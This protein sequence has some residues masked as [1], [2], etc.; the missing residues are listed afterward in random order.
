MPDTT[1]LLNGF[2][3]LDRFAVNTRSNG[4][5]LDKGVMEVSNGRLAFGED[6][7]VTI[8]VQN[9]DANLEVSGSS[10]ITGIKVY[11]S[12]EDYR[13]G[14]VQYSYGPMNPGQSANVQSDVSGLGDTYMRFNANVLVSS[15]AGAPRLDQLLVSSTD[16]RPATTGDTVTFDRYTDVDFNENGEIDDGTTEVA[17]GIFASENNELAAICFARGTMIVTPTG[18][19]AIEDLSPGDLVMTLDEGPQPLRWVGAQEMPGTGM[20]AP[21]RIREGHLG[22]ARDLHVSPNHR[23]MI[24]GHVAE[25]LFGETEVLVAAKHLVNGTTVQREPRAWVSYHHV[26]FDRHQVIFANGCRAE[27]LFPGEQAFSSLTPDARAEVERLTEDRPKATLSRYALSGYEA[28]ALG[29]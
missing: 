8:D 21:I 26:M 22:T 14:V 7:I 23:L 12:A 15:D 6:A 19:R 16:L 5:Y 9:A 25:M 1:I 24:E 17:N 11:A 27:S 18:E 13:A 10:G 4:G 20:N 2:S 28:V 29:H 3:V